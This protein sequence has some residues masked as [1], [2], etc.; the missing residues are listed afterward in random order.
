MSIKKALLK[1]SEIIVDYST[2]YVEFAECPLLKEKVKKAAEKCSK[3]NFKEIR[4]NRITYIGKQNKFAIRLDDK[5]AYKSHSC[6]CKSYLKHSIC[7]HLV[8]FNLKLYGERVS[9]EPVNLYQK[10]KRGKKSGR[11]KKI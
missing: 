4:K 3:S 7:Q 11:P 2:N 1:L 9:D 10:A 6:S 5:E 8:A